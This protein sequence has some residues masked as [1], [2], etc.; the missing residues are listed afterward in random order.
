VSAVTVNL[1]FLTSRR[2]ADL[3]HQ[4][5]AED[6]GDA[7]TLTLLTRLRQSF[8]REEAATALDQARLR[9]KAVDKFGSDAAGLFFT[10]DAGIA[11]AFR[12]A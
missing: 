3:L 12:R 5:D 4:L 10:R 1:A 8:S 7:H 6:L 9:R 11:G 2:G